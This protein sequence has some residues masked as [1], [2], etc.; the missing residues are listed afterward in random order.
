M[1]TMDRELARALHSGPFAL[2]LDLAIGAS[3]LSLERIRHH[4]AERGVTVGRTTLSYWRRGRSR[5][6]RDTSLAA[7][8]A[9]ESV[10]GLPPDALIVLLGPPRPRGRWVHHPPGTF[11]RAQLWPANGPIMA[12]LQAPPH[13]QLRVHTI[14]DLVTLDDRG[15]ER[16]VRTR[17]VVEALVDRVH[18]CLVY[19]QTDD[20]RRP[21]PDLADV[22]HCRPG[23]IRTDPV[24]GSMVAE[25]I[26][27]RRLDTGDHTVLEYELAARDGE[28]LTFYHRRLTRPVRDLLLQVQF[29]GAVPSQC[30]AYRQRS[31]GAPER[32]VRELWIGAFDTVHLIGRDVPP[33]VV[34][35]RW[36]W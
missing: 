4:L 12:Q 20:L 33:G 34:G 28:P 26:L 5:P 9:L 25:L 16:S 22:R 1:A 36:A 31:L 17:L 23:R 3:G 15:A 32:D 29:T 21:L 11:D 35:V 24:T 27:D 8:R 30:H 2:A 19:Y 14:H 18:R 6:E 10:L 7:I 13:E